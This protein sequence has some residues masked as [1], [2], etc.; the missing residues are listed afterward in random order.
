MLGAAALGLSALA[1]GEFADALKD[2]NA[3]HYEAARAQFESLGQLGDCP[4]QFNLGA[5][6]LKGQGGAKDRGAGVGW[7]EAA[8]SNGCR[9]QVGD[10]IPAL[11]A[12]LNP[13]EARAAAGIFARYGYDAL[14]AQ[15]V[16]APN[17][18]CHDQVPPSVIETPAP[19]YPHLSGGQVPE[20]IVVTALT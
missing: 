20:A 15:G 11:L 8:L 1:R 4:S 13:E 19:E 7:L 17:F 16:L 5:M 2:Y 10:R 14:Q 9:Q 12:S 18:D 6:A 3:G